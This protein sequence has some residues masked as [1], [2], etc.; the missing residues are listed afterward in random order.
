MNG[1]RMEVP[2]PGIPVMRVA[3][4]QRMFQYADECR[5]ALIARGEAPM[6]IPHEWIIPAI[7]VRK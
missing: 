2:R 6:V 4:I 7:P 1:V 3:D 5:N